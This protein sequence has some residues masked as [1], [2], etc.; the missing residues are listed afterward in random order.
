MNMI[1]VTISEELTGRYERAAAYL[2]H[3]DVK[4]EKS[5]EEL[6]ELIASECEKIEKNLPLDE[7]MKLEEIANT[8]LCYKAAGK[9]PHR[10]R[11]AAEAMLRRVVKGKGLYRINNVVDVNNLVSVTTG[12][13]I[14][15]FDVSRLSPPL[16]LTV[17]P[18]GTSYQGIGRETVNVEKLPAMRDCE[19]FFGNP[20]SD[21]QRSKIDEGEREILMC[22]YAFGSHENAEKVG[23]A[24]AEL[25]EKYCYGRILGQKLIW[26]GENQCEI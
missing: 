18:E 1:K 20:T 26:K 12:F 23:Q 17:S 16:E 11:N 4:A 25:L 9:D 14:S 24:A 2:I 13:S 15:T 10:Y 19:G 3:A 21:S 22:I 7:I 6:L 8:R 5:S